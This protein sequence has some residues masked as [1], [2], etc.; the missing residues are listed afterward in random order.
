MKVK[1]SI[2]KY[3]P[4]S[5]KQKKVLTW[6][7]TGESP[8]AELDG[9]ICDGSV[10]SGKTLIMSFSYMIW[11]MS[12]FNYTKFGMA[13]KTIGSLRRNVIFTL[14]ILLR[15]RGYGVIE[16]RTDN[17]FICKKKIQG[18]VK[19]NYYYV[20]GGKDESSQDLV[21]G[22]TSGGF[23]FD[24]VA[25]MTESFVNQAVA[26]CSEEGRKLWFNCNPEGP[27]HW[28]Y[29]EWILKKNKKRLYRIHFEL[30]DNPS[31][32]KATKDF[33]KRMFIGVFYKRFILGLWVMA[34]GIIFDMFTDKNIIS[35]PFEK[36][37]AER[38]IIAIDY[39]TQNPCTYGKYGVKKDHYHLFESYY[40]NGRTKGIQKTDKS[41]ADDLEEFV[42]SDKIKYI[43]VDPSATSFIA[44]IRSRDFFKSRNIKVLKAR[45]AV[46][47]GIQALSIKLQ[48]EL[49]TI[50]PDCLDD[51]KEFHSYV[52]NE[53]ATAR[54]LDEPLK[55]NDHC[56]DRNRY[57]VY[58][59]M[60]INHKRISVT[61]KGAM[62]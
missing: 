32:S 21:Q 51:I 55:E 30:D 40:Y 26:R 4:F 57:A 45:N 62:K 61:A 34:Q 38:L 6:W 53:K 35:H 36:N 19:E 2:F 52:W 11:S 48:L 25:L 13:G 49:F 58:T 5:I 54:G 15:L 23:F 43:I 60:K 41:Y 12:S 22:F 20:F 28:F 9:I 29:L 47:K 7:L 27:F 17:Y 39:G 42:G 16:H 56:M 33:L 31:L 8:Y 14:K 37:Q 46:M 24:E 1:N 50:E 10:R 3:T 18:V 59:D 44:E